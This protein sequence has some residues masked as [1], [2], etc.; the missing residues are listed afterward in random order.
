MKNVNH[1]IVKKVPLP[2]C[3][4]KSEKLQAC[5][6]GISMFGE[7]ICD[8]GNYYGVVFMKYSGITGHV[9]NKIILGKR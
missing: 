8:T 2:L 5:F 1:I 9:K 3:Y 4:G 7:I 6:Q